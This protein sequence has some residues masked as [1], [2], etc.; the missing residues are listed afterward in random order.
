MQ[1]NRDKTEFVLLGQLPAKCQRVE[2]D[3]KDRP[4]M[5]LHDRVHS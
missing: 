3:R 5:Q 4:G 1:D 2:S